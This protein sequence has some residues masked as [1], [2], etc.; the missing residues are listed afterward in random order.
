MTDLSIQV[1]YLGVSVSCFGAWI[2]AQE[3][4]IGPMLTA[5]GCA[6]IETL[7]DGAVQA[8]VPVRWLEDIESKG[9]ARIAVSSQG[10]KYRV[11]ID[12]P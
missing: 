4:T 2:N 7:G 9:G 8:R 11:D 12:L 6:D 5:Q 10:V 1:W 3:A